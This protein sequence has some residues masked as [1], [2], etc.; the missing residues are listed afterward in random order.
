MQVIG[1]AIRPATIL[2]VKI[3]SCLTYGK[4]SEQVTARWVR[5]EALADGEEPEGSMREPHRNPLCDLRLKGGVR[6]GNR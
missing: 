5:C 1:L 4:H 3:R 6:G 2:C